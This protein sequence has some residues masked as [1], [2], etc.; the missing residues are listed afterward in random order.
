MRTWTR[1]ILICVL[2][3]VLIL[4]IYFSRPDFHYNKARSAIPSMHVLGSIRA[5]APSQSPLIRKSS[6]TGS[7]QL[8][9]EKE[10][11]KN[12]ARKAK[13]L[14]HLT[15]SQKNLPNDWEEY[16]S[17][18]RKVVHGLWKGNVSSRMLSLRLQKAKSKY[19]TSNTFNVTYRE[20]P[21]KRL[22][23]KELL[24]QLKEQVQV[25]TLNGTEE[26]F[27]SL[28]WGQLVPS[29]PLDRLH[30][31]PFRTCAVVSSAGSILKSSLGKEIDSHD[32]VLRFNAA[33]TVGFEKDVGNKTTIRIINSQVVGN[34]NHKFAG[35][36]FYKNI[37]LV[38]WDPPP[39]SSNL[40]KWY[41]SPDVDFFM[42]YKEHRK[43]S[44]RQPFYI[45]H[46][47]FI[48]SLWSMLQNNTDEKIQS[49]PPSSGYTGSNVWPM[50]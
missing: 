16:F 14:I 9:K 18:G 29:Q 35:N 26:P 40:Q 39:Y 17:N 32:A 27:A 10:H 6:G 46:P 19:T 20:Q 42:A 43:R 25:R 13:T 5:A 30:G 1:F 15:S 22:T 12:N 4:L 8:V 50:Q 48:W 24:C 31:T 47:T 2:G 44:P 11:S 3:W 21:K 41:K 34:P 28:G 33:P 36:S 45:L 38:M 37:T 23:R 49:N 7:E